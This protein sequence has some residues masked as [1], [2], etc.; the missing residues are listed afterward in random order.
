MDEMKPCPFCGNTNID[1]DEVMAQHWAVVLTHERIDYGDFLESQPDILDA[2][3]K[4]IFR[5][6]KQVMEEAETTTVGNRE[7]PQ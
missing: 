6:A 1:P 4:T 3:K 7:P 2:L 5:A